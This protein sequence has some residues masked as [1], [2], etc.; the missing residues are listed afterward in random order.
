[1]SEKNIGKQKQLNISIDE[2]IADG[3]YQTCNY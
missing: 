2:N 1:M 3:V